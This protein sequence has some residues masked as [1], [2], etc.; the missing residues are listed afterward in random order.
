MELPR[1]SGDRGILGLQPGQPAARDFSAE[2]AAHLTPGARPSS[3]PVFRAV[4]NL[5]DRSD[6]SPQPTSVEDAISKT[7]QAA[8][9]Q[10]NF[11]GGGD[12][13]AAA[14]A[15]RRKPGGLRE[16]R[17]SP[18][19]LGGSP[20]EAALTGK[21]LGGAELDK[22]ERGAHLSPPRSRRNVEAVVVVLERDP[23]LGYGLDLRVG[24]ADDKES[25]AG[26]GGYTL[27]GKRLLVARVR[28]G[29]PAATAD[30]EPGDEI[31]GAAVVSGGGREMRPL[32]VGPAYAEAGLSTIRQACAQAHRM[33]WTV[34][35]SRNTSA[36]FTQA[37]VVQTGGQRATAWRE[38]LQSPESAGDGGMG[39][40]V[41]P[42][43][44][45]ATAAP[46]AAVAAVEAEKENTAA[47][48]VGAAGGERRLGPITAGTRG[49]QKAWRPVSPAEE[50]QQ[51]QQQA[52]AAAVARQ[53]RPASAPVMSAEVTVRGGPRQQN[54]SALPTDALPPQSPP[55]PERRD[56]FELPPAAAA[57]PAAQPASP[58]PSAEQESPPPQD[59]WPPAPEPDDEAE[60][61]SLAAARPRP[62][63]R[64]SSS[65]SRSPSPSKAHI[66]ASIPSVLPEPEP[67]PEQLPLVRSETN[68]NPSAQFSH[69]VAAHSFSSHTSAHVRSDG[70]HITF[71]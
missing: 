22:L 52:A 41:K 2:T 1:S 35:R 48:A 71:R 49:I 8:R 65:R 68:R 5:A 69:D 36:G 38:Q 26:S 43:P 10:P 59:A 7:V 61:I 60:E 66:S 58:T 16:M 30:L 57:R 20:G 4:K 13:A 18:N 46:I 34:H 70:L 64:G 51:Q 27:S 44:L 50:E 23:A 67:E 55:L 25:S 15:S 24:G 63:S 40:P 12:S 21:R 53:V 29:T 3:A 17:S 56:H 39:T 14:A 32:E 45:Q 33:R 6:G 28:Q 11:R 31:V 37:D 54:G 47:A 62:H 19:L 9:S 42:L